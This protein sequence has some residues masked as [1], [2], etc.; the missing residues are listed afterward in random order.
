MSVPSV[1]GAI[2]SV[3]SPFQYAVHEPAAAVS[4]NA[5]DRNRAPDCL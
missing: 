5:S 1:A 2:G 3:V 4:R